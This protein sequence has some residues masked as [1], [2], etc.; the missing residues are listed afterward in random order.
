MRA[1]LGNPAV[2]TARKV[3][4]RRD[5]SEHAVAVY[6]ATEQHIT[7]FRRRWEGPYVAAVPVTTLCAD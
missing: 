1:T 2:R 4:S 3:P 5:P 7:E 6:F